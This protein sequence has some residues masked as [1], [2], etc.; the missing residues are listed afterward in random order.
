MKSRRS[1]QGTDEDGHS[2]HHQS[3][4]ESGPHR[5]IVEEMG[6]I[7]VM[8]RDSE[9]EDLCSVLRTPRKQVNKV[10][11]T[12]SYHYESRRPW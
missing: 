6:H 5:L 2:G 10:H 4:V 11:V 3:T 1:D 8:Q 9:G 12:G 7:P